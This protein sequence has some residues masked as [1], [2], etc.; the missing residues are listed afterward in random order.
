M[1]ATRLLDSASPEQRAAVLRVAEYATRLGVRAYVAGG[2][3]RDAFLERPVTDVD[4]VIAGDAISFARGLA[5]AHGGEVVAHER[6]RTA[7]WTID[8]HRHDLASTRTERYSR[9]AALPEVTTGVPIEADLPRRD[10]SLNAMALRIDA[11][12]LVDPLGGAADILARRVRALHANSF[13]DDPTRILRAARYVARLGFEI[14]SA[15]LGWL[16]AG[17]RHLALVSGERL[18]YDI[19]RMFA[20]RAESA[21]ALLAEWGV[22]HALGV[23][24]PEPRAL[25]RRFE[26]MQED[27][28][29]GQFPTGEL[30]L[31]PVDLINAVGWGALIYNQGGFAISRWIDRIPFPIAIREALVDSGPLSTLSANALRGERVSG[32]SATM[33]GFSGAG[34]LLGFLY[35][36]D[37]LKKMAALSEWSVWRHVRPVTTG[38]DLRARGLRPGPEYARIL[39]RLRDAWLD[40]EIQ[41]AE[42]EALLL[43][44]LI[45]AGASKT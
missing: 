2:A 26:Q 8:A 21:V 37:S 35:D 42:D 17:V 44:R 40:G 14:D 5:A 43:D 15:T 7:T 9:P 41:S 39:G 28:A 27:L 25:R 19:E 24:V 6:F 34:L 29:R 4:F 45:T 20:E 10:F 30:G 11:P 38:D 32:L 36:S 12:E 33:R 31:S 1:D 22:F 3:V 23:P 18:K 16:G 13:V